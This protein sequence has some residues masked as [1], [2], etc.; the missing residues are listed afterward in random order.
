MKKIIICGS[1]LTLLCG[2]VIGWV[3]IRPDDDL[4]VRMSESEPAAGDADDPDARAE[5]FMYQRRYPFK[6]VPEGGRRRALDEVLARGDRLGPDAVGTTW[7]PIGPMPT[8]PPPTNPGGSYS[9]RINTIAVSPANN[10]I[11]LIGSAAGG[12]WRSTNGGTSFA[13]VSD[14]Q[15][16][17][18]VGAISFAPSNPN[19]AYA[20]MGDKVARIANNTYFGTGILRSSDAGATW[21]RV[22]NSSIFENGAC[23][24]IRV[25]PTNPNKVY[26]SQSLGNEP[27]T[28]N[29]L[30][31]GIYVSTDGGVNWNNPLRGRSTDIAIH[32]TNPQIV[33][34]AMRRDDA[35]L[36][37]STDGGTS[38]TRVYDSPF[39]TST[40]DFRI[41]VTPASPNRVYVYYGDSTF[42]TGSTQLRLEVSDDL[43]ATWTNRGAIS[44]DAIGLDPVQFSYNT[45]LAASPVDADTIYV[46]SRDVFRSTDG[47]LT[48]TNIVNSFAPPYSVNNFQPTRQKFHSDQQSF[49][50]EP[51]SGTTFYCGN[52]G[53]IWKTTDGGMNFT[54]LNASLSLSQFVG[55]SIDPTNPDRTYGGTQD[56]GTQ[57][58][59]V[60]ANNWDTVFGGDGGKLVV[61]VLDP[62]MV[63]A[64]TTRG[65][66]YRAL[67]YGTSN[68]IQLSPTQTNVAFY[69]PIVGN[70]VDGRLYFGTYLVFICTTCNDPSKVSNFT[71]A[72]DIDLTAGGTDVLSAIAVAKSN[73]QVLYTGSRDGRAM[74]STNGGTSY[75]DI[76]AGLPTRSI[77]NITVSPTDPTLVYLTVSGYATGH[78]FRSTNSGT[79]WTDISGNLPNIPTS[80]FM[81]DPITPTTLYAGTDIGVFRST[82]NG[83][84]WSAFNNGLPPVPIMQFASQAN[85]LIQIAT[86]GRG[87]YELTPTPV[88]NV[89]VSGRVVSPSGLG[90]RNVTISITDPNGVRRT[91]TSSSFGF[92][93][94]DNVQTGQNYTVTVSSRLYRFQQRVVN[95]SGELTNID[96]IGLE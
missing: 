90:L 57:R 96:F 74:L 71:S 13:P 65:F 11:V 52:D 49:A 50:F 28:G 7:F 27:T 24:A 55:V 25:D 95:V 92:Y 58:R 77:T 30:A 22:N 82:D 40:G 33:Y 14:T 39:G 32:P 17:L 63:F 94:F 93:S 88:P 69:P 59:N 81:I 38:W 20:A 73:T 36:Y 31:S 23:T 29:V 26:V 85:G 75:T 43:G 70:G 44:T 89:S 62:S 47:G 45:Y 60:G 48:F 61:N 64:S 78:I 2:L 67:N 5:W 72:N 87:M 83:A 3:T 91:A 12:I 53:G 51:G 18:A 34:A 46:G 9:G 86:Y 16:D 56:N 79:N 15:V 66:I 1:I 19:I 76:T 42:G 35:G 68:L 54:S 41:A 37:R 84:G 10:Q 4:A 80:A 21:T 6:D 8:N